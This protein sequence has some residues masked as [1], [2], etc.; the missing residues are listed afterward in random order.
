MGQFE[1]KSRNFFSTLKEAFT[2]KE[3]KVVTAREA[4]MTAKYG[5]PITEEALYDETIKVINHAIKEK[6]HNS[7]DC[8]LIKNLRPEMAPYYNDLIKYYED[9]GYTVYLINQNSTIDKKPVIGISSP[10]VIITWGNFV[11]VRYTESEQDE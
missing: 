3:H 4:Y 8:A 9:K 10:M 5:A 1:E 2:L 6:V 11:P 7:L